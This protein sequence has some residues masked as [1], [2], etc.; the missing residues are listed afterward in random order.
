MAYGYSGTSVRFITPWFDARTGK[1]VGGEGLEPVPCIRIRP[2]TDGGSDHESFQEALDTLDRMQNIKEGETM[3]ALWR[4]RAVS[5]KKLK[6]VFDEDNIIA[7]DEAEATLK[8]GL[9]RKLQELNLDL[10][11]VWTDATV[12]DNYFIPMPK[13]IQRVKIE[14]ED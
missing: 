4:I 10:D 2:R 12:S 13:D 5:R 6:V 14:K 8:S 11:A 1:E 3:R 7:K 9:M